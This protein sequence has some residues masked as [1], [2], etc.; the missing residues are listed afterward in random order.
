M[1]YRELKAQLEKF[2]EEQLDQDVTVYVS[3]E[4]EYFGLVQDF[5]I[6]ESEADDVLDAGHKY[7]VI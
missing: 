6:C 4:G 1:K 2:T 7:L 3:G 5:P